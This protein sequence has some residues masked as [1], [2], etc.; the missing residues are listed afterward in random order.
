MN[1]GAGSFNLPEWVLV[2]NGKFTVLTITKKVNK[3]ASH[4]EIY[5]SYVSTL[6]QL[7]KICDAATY[8]VHQKESYPIQN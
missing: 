6:E 4:K 5:D 1:F 2:K 8:T 3:T 7:D